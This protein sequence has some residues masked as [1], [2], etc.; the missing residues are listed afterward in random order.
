VRWLTLYARSRQIPLTAGLALLITMGIWGLGKIWDGDGAGSVLAALG[1]SAGAAVAG[2]SLGASDFALERTAA[3]VWFPRRALHVVGVAVVLG[4]LLLAV[5]LS[6]PGFAVR[7]SLGFAGLAALGAV[8]AGGQYAWIP[9]IT[10]LAVAFVVPVGTGT[11][12]WVL[13]WLV[14]PS[15]TTAA[16]V[17]AVTL[18]V[19]G[20]AAYAAFGARR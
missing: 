12:T 10:W 19:L 7:D 1:L 5:R 9:P 3:I 13:R 15:G 16:T 8:V 17:T 20:T 6:T 4:G 11:G 18:A 2:T 14:Q